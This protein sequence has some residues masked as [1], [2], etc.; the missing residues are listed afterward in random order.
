MNMTTVQTIQLEPHWKN[1]LQAEFDKPYMQQLRTFLAQELQAGKV[2]LPRGAAM[3]NAFSQTPLPAVKVV[4]LGQ[5]PYHGVGQAHGLSFSVRPGVTPP[6]SLL[7]IY[8][9]LQ[10]DVGFKPVKHGYLQ[11]WAQQGVLLLNSVLTVEQG[12]PTSHRNRG[13]ETFTDR[14]IAILAQEREHLVFLL[15]GAYAQQKGKIIDRSRHLVLTA[16]HPSP[17]ARV[18]F[19]GCRHFSQT[20]AYLVHNEQTP[21]DWQLPEQVFE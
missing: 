2:I 5:D 11:H 13:W 6:P 1:A 14:A 10:A 16:A 20:N 17:L 15:W 21:I 7:N 9:E 4:L 19:L 12:K 8:K 3:F 18:G